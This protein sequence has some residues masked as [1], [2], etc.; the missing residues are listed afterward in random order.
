MG[1][2]DK[3]KEV[4]EIGAKCYRKFLLPKDV[5]SGVIHLVGFRHIITQELHGFLLYTVG[6][7]WWSTKCI[8][9]SELAV[10]SMKPNS[11]IGRKAA[12]Y[13]NSLITYKIADIVETGSAILGKSTIGNS[14]KKL[15]FHES[16]VYIKSHER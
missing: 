15:G 7:P 16:S 14:Y 6:V 2:I 13:L 1:D 3:L 12:N 8:G 4:F 10:M 9:I 11:G 5:S